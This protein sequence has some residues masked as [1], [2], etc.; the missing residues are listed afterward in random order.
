MVSTSS[1]RRLRLL[2]ALLAC[3]VV[4]AAPATAAASAG[5]KG[6]LKVHAKADKS[7]VKVNEKV[8]IKGGLDVLSGGSGHDATSGR[9]PV[10][11][12]S[13]QAGVWVNVSTGWCR[14]N[15]GF[16]LS[17]SFDLAASLSLRV[18]H[19]ET[20]LYASAYSGVFSLVVT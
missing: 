12:Q 14:P 8:K 15:G 9:E 19:P 6:Q 2:T 1:A 17:V 18:F 3:L 20:D 16:S 4:F 13:L 7:V 11:L 10:L 5:P